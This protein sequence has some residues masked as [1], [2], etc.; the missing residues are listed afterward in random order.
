MLR[1]LVLLVEDVVQGAVTRL[2]TLTRMDRVFSLH[3]DVDA[4]IQKMAG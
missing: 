4:A 2:F 3:P 1:R